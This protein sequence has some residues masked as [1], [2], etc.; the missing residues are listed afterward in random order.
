MT[1]IIK[2]FIIIVI[3]WDRGGLSLGYSLQEGKTDLF[4]KNMKDEEIVSI[5][6]DGDHLALDYLLNKYK[7][8]V[9]GKATTYFL[10][11][12]DRDDII[13]EGMIG[14]FKAIRDY[15]K[16]KLTS[17]KSFAE[18]CITRQIIT[19]IKT[20]TRKKHIPLN[21]YI[22]LNKPVYEEGSD[23]TLLD[24]IEGF[25]VSDP[26]EVCIGN[27]NIHNIEI[28]I[29]NSLSELEYEVLDSYIKGSTYQDIAK[30]LNRDPKSVDNALQRTKKKLG[31]CLDYS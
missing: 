10:I 19:A 30:E 22:S 5:A 3:A 4:Y 8:Y 27:E 18:I 23:R 20:A 13:Q 9:R 12:A 11:G 14:L 6:R 29:L 1:I 17:F 31:K 25:T 16:D 15:N 26:M 2:L 24:M 7:N 21:S 28:D